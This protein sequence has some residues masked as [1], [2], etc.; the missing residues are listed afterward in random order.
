MLN[1]VCLIGIILLILPSAQAVS[2][3]SASGQLAGKLEDEQLEFYHSDSLGSTRAMTDELGAVTER[4]K[5][6]P[7]GGVL[8]GDE[9][10]GF[11]GKELDESGLQYFGSRYYDSG[12]GR[13]ISTDPA[14]QYHSP[15][16]YSGNNP[17]A[18]KD[19]DGNMAQFAPAIP[20][21]ATPLGWAFIGGGLI[22]TGFM[23]WQGQQWL[24]GY[25]V[26]NIGPFNEEYM[27]AS[28]PDLTEGFTPAP[29]LDL[30]ERLTPAPADATR[31]VEGY[32]TPNM[33][34]MSTLA[35]TSFAPFEPERFKQAAEE[36]I[37]EMPS[38]R[39]YFKKELMK[40]RASETW[41]V[42]AGPDAWLGDAANRL[43][44]RLGTGQFHLQAGNGRITSFH[45][46]GWNTYTHKFLEYG[47]LILDSSM[48]GLFE[49]GFMDGPFLGTKQ[50]LGD[51]VRGNFD[52]MS[53]PNSWGNIQNADDALRV[54]WSMGQ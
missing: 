39:R 5:S 13:F 47:D 44:V 52:K 46:G 28:M 12:T 32:S 3:L 50:E 26:P 22:I 17:V 37:G 53:F 51:L 33:P 6:L 11:T 54:G 35:S 30:T 14:M 18:Y 48:D 21:L 8:A 4:Q 41:D 15:Y 27:P 1:K 40:D 16:V 29:P 24:E 23:A 20:F 2:Y 25:E 36:I 49:P 31:F 7:F 9:K 42:R 19:P 45:V 38:P 43:R 10:Y 34:D